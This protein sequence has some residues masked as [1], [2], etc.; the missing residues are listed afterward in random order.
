MEA[1]RRDEEHIT[2]LREQN[3]CLLAKVTTNNRDAMDLKAAIKALKNV[4]KTLDWK[5]NRPPP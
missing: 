5:E 1:T 3:T 2:S 4:V